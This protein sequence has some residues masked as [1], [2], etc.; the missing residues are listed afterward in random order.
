MDSNMF[1]KRREK[2]DLFKAF[3]NKTVPVKERSVPDDLYT[4][5]P[6]CGG[7]VLT[8]RFREEFPTVGNTVYWGYGTG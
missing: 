1:H 3:R 4:K 5:C 6:A 8:S 2:L 7:T